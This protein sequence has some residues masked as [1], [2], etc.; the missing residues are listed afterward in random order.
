MYCCLVRLII[1][2]FQVSFS[3]CVKR[4]VDSQSFIWKMKQGPRLLRNGLLAIACLDVLFNYLFIY[5][6]IYSLYIFLCLF[7]MFPSIDF[8]FNLLFV[9]N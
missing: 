4:S 2:H 5:L 3:L 7:Y 6:F 9:R 1:S 8:F